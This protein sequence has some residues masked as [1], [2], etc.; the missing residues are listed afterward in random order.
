AQLLAL[1]GVGPETADAILLYVAQQ[2]IFV[3][4]AYTRRVLGRLGYAAPDVSYDELQALFMENLS[5]SV[6]LFQEYHAL[7]DV[8]AKF[9]CT[10]R[11]PRCP[12]CPLNDICPKIGVHAP[13][14]LAPIPK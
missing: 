8:H 7:L 5:S 1:H 4:D 2:P 9:T 11:A 3:I 10:K 12:S 6:P 14:L 13:A